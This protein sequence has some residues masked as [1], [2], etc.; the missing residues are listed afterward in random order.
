VT[1]TFIPISR[2]SIT[3]REIACVTDAVRSGWVSSL[4]AYVDLFEQ[5]F[6]ACVG[7]RYAVTASNGTTAL[8]LALAAHDIG[9]GDEVVIPDLTFV[10]TANAVRYTGATVVCADVD[11]DTLCLDPESLRQVV[12]ERTRAVIPVHLYGHPADMTEILAVAREH[13]LI[14][15]EDAA[16]AHGAELLGRRAGSLGRCGVFS[17]YGNKIITSGEGGM[18]TTDDPGL[19]ERLRLLRDH[20]MSRTKRYWHEQV[21]FNYRMTNLQAALGVAQLERIEELLAR[22]REIFLRYRELLS[23]FPGIRLNREASWAKHVYWMVCL[24]VEGYDE[25][26][27]DRLMERL[28]Q[29]GVDSRPYFYPVSDLPMYA[30]ADTPVA[31]AVSRRGINLPSFADMDDASIVHV[32]ESVAAVLKAGPE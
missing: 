13:G 26:G 32:C 20:A 28:R 17:F 27:R 25:A 7:T 21:G 3:E 31:H 8:H 19:H 22:K 15:I 18:I 23:G 14:V 11:A 16:E 4:G 1:T 5:R 9:P 12:T 29:R 2:P 30:A 24:E 6:A 10:A